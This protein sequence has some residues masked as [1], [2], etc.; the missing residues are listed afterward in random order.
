[1]PASHW[2]EPAAA[3]L[4]LLLLLLC[5]CLRTVYIECHMLQFKAKHKHEVAC[6]LLIPLVHTTSSS[7]SNQKFSS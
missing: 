6:Q 3:M 1:M 4:L 5:A 7:S 2:P